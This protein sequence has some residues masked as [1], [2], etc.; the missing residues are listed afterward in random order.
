MTSSDSL[1]INEMKLPEN[2]NILR[3][4][5]I[6]ASCLFMLS[7]CTSVDHENQY[8]IKQHF[9]SHARPIVK[10]YKIGDRKTQY[11]EIGTPGEAIVLFIHGSPGSWR[12]FHRLLNDNELQESTHMIAV[13]RPGYGGS[14]SGKYISSIRQQAQLLLPLINSHEIGRPIILVG[15]SYGG[16]VAAWM[17]LDRPD[18]VSGLVLIAPALDPTLEG[19]NWYQMMTKSTPMRWLIPKDYRTANEEIV[20]LKAELQAL[21]PHWAALKL[22]VVHIHGE[23]DKLVP[24]STLEFSKKVM[25]QA[26][27][28]TVHLPNKN[29]YIPWNDRNTIKKAILDIVNNNHNV[30]ERA[31][32]PT[33]GHRIQSPVK[34]WNDPKDQ[35]HIEEMGPG[36]F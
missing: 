33:P 16:P 36:I 1:N 29:H 3:F 21:L 8:F 10:S 13:D 25:I 5:A 9:P 28:K 35:L 11:V 34:K 27:L 31:S 22:P 18:L 26:D 15:H 32:D 14:N 4:V 20:Q 2:V 12:A 30:E 24:V 7:G 6:W 19:V 23:L 17:A